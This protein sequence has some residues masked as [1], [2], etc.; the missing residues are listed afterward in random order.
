MRGRDLST[1]CFNSFAR[2][3]GMVPTAISPA[4]ITASQEAAIMALLG[5]R[6]STRLPGTRPRS[7]TSTRA[8]W[9]TR[10]CNWA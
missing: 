5:P 10:Y 3:I 1:I 2:S 7:S 8:I 4:L 6:S 9:L